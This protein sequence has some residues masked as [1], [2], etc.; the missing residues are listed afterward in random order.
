MGRARAR[1][2]LYKAPDGAEMFLLFQDNT[3]PE[4]DP[5]EWSAAFTERT[6]R[7][8]FA[9]RVLN[10]AWALGETAILVWYVYNIATRFIGDNAS[11]GTSV[12]YTNPAAQTFPMVS[13][14]GYPGTY[15][16]S[17]LLCL[18]Y[19]GEESAEH[20]VRDCMTDVRALNITTDAGAPLS[21]FQFNYNASEPRNA[22]GVGFFFSV[23]LYLSMPASPQAFLD[24]VVI[25]YTPIGR[26]L[27]VDDV[28]SST[29]YAQA[30]QSTVVSLAELV[31]V[32]V[33]GNTNRSW[34]AVSA[35]LQNSPQLVS[36]NN[37]TTPLSR[38]I[39]V[40]T[41]YRLLAVQTVTQQY[42]YPL[43]SLFG[44]FAGMTG[45]LTGLHLSCFIFG[46]EKLVLRCRAWLEHRR[47]KQ[48][49][50][51]TQLAAASA[52]VPMQSV[53]SAPGKQPV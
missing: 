1:A 19:D 27:G 6:R 52:G 40:S 17:A 41:S 28:L 4:Y 53:H 3:A 14:C 39:Y 24:A 21:C 12:S 8:R 18:Q 9:F 45:I 50:R 25:A 33:R 48:L 43:T 49:A 30:G 13:V 23:D 10:F 46:A 47:V 38:L 35:S 42:A 5:D 31:Q 20:P 22:T 16:P 44:D 2:D 15:A 51:P 7:L 36:E 34:A 32:D 29:T 11:P 26:G 37:L